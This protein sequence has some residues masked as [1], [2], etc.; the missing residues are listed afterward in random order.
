[1]KPCCI[2]ATSNFP[3]KAKSPLALPSLLLPAA[4]TGAC[5]WGCWCPLRGHTHTPRCTHHSTAS[6]VLGSSPQSLSPVCFCGEPYEPLEWPALTWGFQALLAAVPAAM[7]TAVVT[8]LMTAMVTAV[9]QGPSHL[10][11]TSGADIMQTRQ[12]PGR[13]VIRHVIS[14][15]LKFWSRS[16]FTFPVR[17]EVVSLDGVAGP[18]TS[19]SV[20]QIFTECI[21]DEQKDEWLALPSFHAQCRGGHRVTARSAMPPAG[22]EVPQGGLGSERKI[23][24]FQHKKNSALS[25]R[26]MKLL[27]C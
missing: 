21:K 6:A 19:H 3:D 25:K 8:A 16:P 2:L 1:M 23:L 4:P 9:L 17:V 14:R 10:G 11:G 27:A 26:V 12:V 20:Q 7:V 15:P 13:H 18:Q 5:G 24:L 22:V